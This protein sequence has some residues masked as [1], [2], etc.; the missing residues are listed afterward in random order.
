M[1]SLN[2][3]I[4]TSVDNIYKENPVV[5]ELRNEVATE[6][7]QVDYASFFKEKRT[8]FKILAIIFLCFTLIFLARYDVDL[9]LNFERVFGFI[10][11]GFGNETGLVGDIISATTGA[12]D[13]DIFG[14][15]SLAELGREEMTVNINRV[16]Y[17]INMDDVKDPSKKDFEQSLFPEDIGLEEAEVYN[18]DILKENQELVKN[19]FRNMATG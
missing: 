13:E 2:E 7:K 10:E 8:S 1:P 9:K 17:E 6:M 15:E 12:P 16:G 11:G 3:K 19:Y 14:D 5:D 4:R 18:K